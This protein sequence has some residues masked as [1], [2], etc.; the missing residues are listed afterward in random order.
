[1]YKCSEPSCDRYF[2]RHSSYRNH[3]KTHNN[4]IENLLQEATIEKRKDEIGSFVLGFREEIENIEPR[5]GDHID[6]EITNADDRNNEIDNEI[7]DEAEFED[8]EAEFDEIDEIE[9]VYIVCSTYNH[10]L[11]LRVRLSLRV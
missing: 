9:E 6:Y 3:I 7:D 8:D 4:I 5:F 10:L 11:E 2:S 1:M